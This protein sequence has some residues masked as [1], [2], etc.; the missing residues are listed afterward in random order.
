M[1]RDALAVLVRAPKPRVRVCAP[2]ASVV[3]VKS[4]SGAV[5]MTSGDR[6]TVREPGWYASPAASA[7]LTLAFV[8]V[9]NAGIARSTW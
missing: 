9:A 4:P 6:P 1:V 8:S 2:A 7:S 3:T 5:A